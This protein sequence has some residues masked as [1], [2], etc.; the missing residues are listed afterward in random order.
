MIAEFLH[1]PATDIDRT[2]E[3][4]Y[5]LKFIIKKSQV[6]SLI[7]IYE[8]SMGNMERKQLESMI[9]N[10]TIVMNEHGATCA[11]FVEK[12]DTKEKLFSE[13]EEYCNFTLGIEIRR[14]QIFV[15]KTVQSTDIPLPNILKANYVNFLRHCRDFPRWMEYMCNESLHPLCRKLPK[16]DM[17][18]W[19][20]EMERLTPLHSQRFKNCAEEIQPFIEDENNLVICCLMLLLKREKED[21]PLY[22]WLHKMLFKNISN[23]S[24]TFPD[25]NEAIRDLFKAI[26]EIFAT[27][28]PTIVSVLP[29]EE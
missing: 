14:L 9:Q 2:L 10:W 13:F 7:S 24:L 12:V 20:E 8:D 23:N 29:N 1:S 25:A 18:S 3:L 22:K 19:P 21:N 16:Y 4:L 6:V 15:K 28:H 17:V 26:E 27:V 11:S 5:Q